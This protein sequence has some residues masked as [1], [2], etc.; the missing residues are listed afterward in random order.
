MKNSTSLIYSGYQRLLNYPWFL[1]IFIFVLVLFAAYQSRNFSF[2]ASSDTLVAESDPDLNYYQAV[3]E[4]FSQGGEGFLFLTYTPYNGELISPKNLS[5]VSSLKKKLEKIH[6]ISSVYTILD[7]PLLKSPPVSLSELKDEFKTLATSGVDLSQAKQELVNSPIFKDL[8][9]SADGKTTVLRIGLN[10][11]SKLEPLRKKRD[12]DRIAFKKGEIDEQVLVQSTT[13]HQV[14]REQYLLDRELLLAEVRQVRDQAR[15]NA[16]VFL[17]GVP[18]VAADMISFV[19]QDIVTFSA[20]ILLVVG[21]MLYLFFRRWRWVVLPIL[22]S[23]VSIMLII[24]WLGAIGKPATIISSNFISLLTILTISF[25]IHLIVRY[26]EI[27]CLQPE[28]DHKSIVLQT[29]R[30]KLAPSVYTGLT[31]TVAFGSFTFTDIVPVEDFGLLMSIGVVVSL[32]VTYTFFPALLLLLAKG[33]PAKSLA[34]TPF[35]TTCFAYLVNLHS[36]R[37]LLVGLLSLIVAGFGISKIS[38]DNRFIDYF[39]ADTDI[40]QGMI[41]IDQRLGG[42]LPFDVI[43]KFPPFEAASQ[44]SV[45]DDFFSEEEKYPERYWVTPDKLKTLAELQDYIES[46]DQTGKVISLSN[47]EKVAMDFTDDKPLDA[48]QI[49][50]V[51]GAIPESIRAELID[52]YF[53]PYSGELLISVRAKESGPSFSREA[54]LNKIQAYAVEKLGL[55]AKDVHTT[56]MM[57]LFNNMLKHLFD[58]QLT[59]FV[60]VVGLIFVMFLILMRSIKLALIGMLPNVLAAASVLAVMGFLNI[61]L[62]L[63]TIT[64]AAIVIGIGVDDAIHYLHRFKIEFRSTGDVKEAV[65]NSHKS[66]GSAIYFTSFTIIAGF[67]VLAFS[68]FVPTVYF[69]LFTSL[70]MLLALMANLTILPSLLVKFYH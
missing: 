39:K 59:T 26:R 53:S 50:G 45:D 27:L 25:T 20:I 52:P 4:R 51:L 16:K 9:I 44:V 56:G 31:T 34:K 11:D 12:E 21:A 68:N 69:G 33:R 6:G 70:A 55:Q 3:R 36:S 28:D 46:L 19:K 47:L 2:D 57:V 18:M 7:A 29:M 67:S 63:M 22:T 61:P 65:R 35:I 54:Y 60:Y 48:L 40:R 8:L 62:D 66:I 64:I 5:R 23:A 37:I 42:T 49:A 32:L 43:I 41:D 17:G 15:K 58:S 14:A 24:G 10:L 13:A 30:N 38:L 1:L